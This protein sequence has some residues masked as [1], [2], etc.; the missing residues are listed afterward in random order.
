MSETVPPGD[1]PGTT[2]PWRQVH[3]VGAAA[4][5]SA[6]AGEG[7]T[8]GAAAG[9]VAGA[10]AALVAI[11]PDVATVQA[12][13]ED[14]TTK[15]GQVE[16]D[17]NATEAAAGDARLSRDQSQA[18]KDAAEAAAQLT[19]SVV[20]NNP[21]TV[22][23]RAE[24]EALTS[25][26]GTEPPQ[27]LRPR[28]LATVLHEGQLYVRSEDNMRWDWYAAAPP[29]LQRRL[30]A[31][32]ISPV[33]NI[34]GVGLAI[35]DRGGR[36]VLLTSADG[37]DIKAGVMHGRR[38]P[39]GAVRVG[40]SLSNVGID[41]L[42]D[43][44]LRLD[45]VA[46]APDGLSVVADASGAVG[47]I[48][49][50][51]GSI[52]SWR[53][54]VSNRAKPGLIRSRRPLN[55]G[56]TAISANQTV[57]TTWCLEDDFD[58]VRLVFE[59]DT[60][61]PYTVTKALVAPSASPN[62]AGG[63][64]PIDAAGSA[65]SWVPVTFDGLGAD[66]GPRPTPGSVL[67]V[68]V[69]GIGANQVKSY[70][71]SDWIRISS[72]LPAP[73][74]PSQQL[75]YAMTRSFY[76]GAA[77]GQRWAGLDTAVSSPYSLGRIGRGLLG[78]GDATSGAFPTAISTGWSVPA[79][80]QYYSRSRGATIVNLGDSI[81]QGTG[82]VGDAVGWAHL[83]CGQL[84]K[85]GRPVS[86]C[87]A[88]W[89]GQSSL[90]FY[91]RGRQEVDISRPSVMPIA[92]FSPNDGTPTQASVNASFSRAI[93]L[94][95]YAISLGVVPI[96]LTPIPWVSLT[97]ETDA[98]RLQLVTRLRAMASS[99]SI[100]VLDMDA[101]VSDGATP[102]RIQPEYDADGTH[103]SD[104]GQRAVAREAVQLF[105]RILGYGGAR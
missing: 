80:L 39:D 20:V 43:G 28:L 62:E 32:G 33:V 105:S 58:L 22:L 79:I 83:A 61:T 54:D 9:A 100:L 52:D 5:A 11:A 40:S 97:A 67:T 78:A 50:R 74:N 41:H 13:R 26:P 59:N 104:A 86:L 75:R 65:V 1:V 68:T 30:S 7:G 16:Q 36:A 69:P 84:S 70:A 94:A 63:H 82:S 81:S 101:I 48:E 51:D 57:H 15:A 18:A 91:L 45:R 60:A 42:R 27:P 12:A 95:D 76:S 25:I 92:V 56:L 98:L 87:N 35:T 90:N 66:L 88:G 85:A 6:G 72:L 49:R 17:R 103:L 34:P 55:R 10:E 29:E 102:A 93:D 24:L 46:G 89:G 71:C 14:V 77:R 53:V 19:S 37:L 8:A 73:A 23:T 38:L 44:S 96:F 64:Q 31:L 2:T 47:V 3:Q 99:G 21:I 4:G